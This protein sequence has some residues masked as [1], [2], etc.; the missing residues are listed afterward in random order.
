[1]LVLAGPSVD[2]AVFQELTLLRL[3]RQFAT[4]SSSASATKHRQQ[5]FR[6]ALIDLYQQHLI[7]TD[8]LQCMITGLR[9]PAREVIA[10]PLLARK[11]E[12]VHGLTRVCRLIKD[13]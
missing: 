6:K 7:G 4:P 11:S 10:G 12:M 3:E 8:Q 2:Q 1:M 9:L 5:Q 13:I